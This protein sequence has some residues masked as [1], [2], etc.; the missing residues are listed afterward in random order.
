MSRL[1]G[2]WDR[3]RNN[4]LVIGVSAVLVFLILVP[5]VRLIIN[6]FIEG[7]PSVPEGW[8]LNNYVS[9]YSMPI[10]YEALATTLW[11]SSIGTFVTLAIAVLFAWLIERTDMP[12]RNMAWVLILVPMAIP[13][14]LFALGWTLLLSPKV[15]ALNM[16]L[17]EFFAIVGIIFENG[18][19]NI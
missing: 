19:I 10:F 13:G 2:A 12:F 11:I 16:L 9:A 17:R 8:T 4:V 1:G 7:H 15:G 5:V 18:P 6:S 3:I 14:V